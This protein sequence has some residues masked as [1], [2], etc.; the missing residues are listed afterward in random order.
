ME[1]PRYGNCFKRSCYKQKIDHQHTADE[2]KTKNVL[3]QNF[4]KTCNPDVVAR[5]KQQKAL[6]VHNFI[7]LTIM[8]FF[9]SLLILRTDL[10]DLKPDWLYF[11]ARLRGTQTAEKGFNSSQRRSS[12]I[13][14][15]AQNNIIAISSPFQQV[16]LQAQCRISPRRPSS[17]QQIQM[18][19]KAKC[20]WTEKTRG[21]GWGEERGGGGERGKCR[22]NKIILFTSMI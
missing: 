18:C 19:I 15:G 17:C 4:R 6:H 14:N 3:Y 16:S 9:A 21:N 1:S 22:A 10:G 12:K 11:A 13:H 8:L 5:L 7:N 20:S 2:K